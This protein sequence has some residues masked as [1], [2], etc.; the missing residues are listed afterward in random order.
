MC[1][2]GPS[3]GVACHLGAALVESS[4]SDV[5]EHSDGE[6]VFQDIAEQPK[7]L[8]VMHLSCYRPLSSG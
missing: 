5:I 8:P 2:P 4:F 7:L 1:G 3:V 6:K